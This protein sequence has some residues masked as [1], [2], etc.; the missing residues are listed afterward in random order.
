MANRTIKQQIA[1]LNLI[2][3]KEGESVKYYSKA[4]N[5]AE[6]QVSLAKEQ[7]KELKK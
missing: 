7:L 2:I 1:T 6:V 5:A 3:K 4:L